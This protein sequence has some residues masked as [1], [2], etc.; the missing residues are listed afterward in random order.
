MKAKSNKIRKLFV[1]DIKSLSNKKNSKIPFDAFWKK[2]KILNNI[3]L[4]SE[5]QRNNQTRFVFNS[6]YIP[7][8]F[9]FGIFPEN[10]LET[11]L[12]ICSRC[13]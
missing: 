12:G 6:L 1:K 10:Y 8:T 2:K 9:V 4:A 5:N 3:L 13:V 7:F 11:L